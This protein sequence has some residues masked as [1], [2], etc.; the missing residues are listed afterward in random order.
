MSEPT[1]TKT[2]PLP[3][4]GETFD[5][6][7]IGAGVAGAVASLLAARRGWSVLLVEKQ[8]LPRH[9]VCGGCL[10][11]RAVQLLERLGLADG[12]KQLNGESTDHLMIRSGRRHLRVDMP[13]GISVSRSLLDGWLTQEAVQAG[14]RLCDGVT[15]TVGADVGAD[16]S[17]VESNDHEAD[18]RFMRSERS[19]IDRSVFRVVELQKNAA[20]SFAG[21]MPRQLLP[22]VSSQILARVVLVC[23]GLG[24]PS[25]R[26][27]PQFSA[28][29]RQGSRIGLGARFDRT[30]ADD[31]LPPGEILMAVGRGGY[32]GLVQTEQGQLNLAAAVE[33]KLLRDGRS[34]RDC[35]A[36]LLRSAG[37]PVPALLSQAHIRGTIPLTRSARRCAD[38]RI[39]LL[40][41]ATG[42]VE[43]FTGEGMAWAIQSAVDVVSLLSD[44]AHRSDW[45]PSLEQRWSAICRRAARRDQTWCRMLSMILHR[46]WLLPT[47]MTTCRALPSI[48]QHIVR[49]INLPSSVSDTW[50]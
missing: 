24:H 44:R 31:W 13:P 30:P 23:D 22:S 5:V 40:G 6:V 27:L 46:G 9:K 15:A 48:P 10:S 41:D 34:S 47:V 3:A 39:L 17:A 50:E 42:Y 33:P 16:A 18:G 14:V 43:P 2:A 29:P 38:F 1:A 8:R 7:V 32:V 21:E 25:V 12:L 28:M 19:G 4:S 49:R 45:S 11:F 35:L 26:H 20:V 37:V 36:E